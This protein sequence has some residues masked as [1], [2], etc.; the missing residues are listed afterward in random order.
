MAGRSYKTE[1]IVLRSFRLGEAARVLDVLDAAPSRAPARPSLDP[2][3]LAF[4]LKLLWLSGYLPHLGSCTECGSE[5]PVVGYSPRAGGAVC[6]NCAADALTLS[7]PGIA[8]IDGLL[9]RP[10]A[11][12]GAVALTER[13]AREALSVITAWYEFHGGFRLRTLSA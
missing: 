4:Q 10:L 3:A 2:L 1:A 11:E 5:G 8:A 7:P 13:S 6:R 9:R 12:A